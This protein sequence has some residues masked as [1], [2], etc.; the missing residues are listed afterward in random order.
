MELNIR[1]SLDWPLDVS[2]LEEER[3]AILRSAC[4][5]QLRTL[6]IR[7]H[8]PAGSLRHRRNFDMEDQVETEVKAS[9]MVR[10]LY[11]SAQDLGDIAER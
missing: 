10:E 11:D 9:N 3:S 2:V 1:L 6:T 7:F 8:I 5:R 4:M